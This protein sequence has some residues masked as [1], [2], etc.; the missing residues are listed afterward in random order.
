MHCAVYE[1]KKRAKRIQNQ[2]TLHFI[3]LPPDTWVIE[4]RPRL[5]CHHEIHTVRM[6]T[7]IVLLIEV[8]LYQT[9]NLDHWAT[10]DHVT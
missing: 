8:Y 2:N 5:Y 9:E 7:L 4:P 1:K 10:A 3:L 6:K